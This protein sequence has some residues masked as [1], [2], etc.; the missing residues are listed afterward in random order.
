MALSRFSLE[1]SRRSG[2]EGFAKSRRPRENAPA[3]P[4]LS[5]FRTSNQVLSAGTRGFRVEADGLPRYRYEENLAATPRNGLSA[6][7]HQSTFR[8]KKIRDVVA[9][10][11]WQVFFSKFSSDRHDPVCRI[12]SNLLRAGHDYLRLHAA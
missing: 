3:N 4:Q 8:M 9:H 6:M 11:S 10:Y 7:E 2:R 1:C 5:S 12:E